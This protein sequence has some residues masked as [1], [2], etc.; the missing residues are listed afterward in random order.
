MKF[1]SFLLAL[2]ALALL[3]AASEAGDCSLASRLSERPRLF[4]NLFRA[5]AAAVETSTVTQTTKVTTTSS[6]VT[7]NKARGPVV[8]VPAPAAKPAVK[9]SA[10]AVKAAPCNCKAGCTCEACDCVKPAKKS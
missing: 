10:P 9:K 7:T 2:F 5:R 6:T 1:C 8:V 4:G 3:P